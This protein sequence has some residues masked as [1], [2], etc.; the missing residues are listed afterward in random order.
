MLVELT[1]TKIRYRNEG[2]E[3]LQLFGILKQYI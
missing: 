2:K 3:N 1:S